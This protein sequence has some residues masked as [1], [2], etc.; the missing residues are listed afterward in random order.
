MFQ[1]CLLPLKRWSTPTRLHGTV[2]QKALIFLI[3]IINR[4]RTRKREDLE[5]KYLRLE[6]FICIMQMDNDRLLRAA[7]DMGMKSS[8]HIREP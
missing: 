7:L 1:R 5:R 8:G 3:R 2:S 6:L 4:D